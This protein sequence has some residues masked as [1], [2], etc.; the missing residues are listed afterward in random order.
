MQISL[1]Q[2]PF[3]WNLKTVT[4]FYREMASL[5]LDTIYIGNTVCSKRETTISTKQWL[6]IAEK[7]QATDKKVIFSTLGLI[8]TTAELSQ[9]TN[10]CADTPFLI[11][12]NDIGT[13][14][15]LNHHNKEFACGPGINIYNHNTAKI[16]QDK[17]MVRWTPPIE[18]SIN[19]IAEIKSASENLNA[20][21]DLYAFG[22]L[23]L[24]ISARCYSARV[25]E[26]DKE[27][28][29]N[30]CTKKPYG[31]MVDTTDGRDFLRINGTQ[32]MS[33]AIHNSLNA[34]KLAESTGIDSLRISPA[35][36]DIKQVIEQTHK[37]LKGEMPAVEI[38][39]DPRERFCQGFAFDGAGIE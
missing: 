7:L 25:E 17:G 10:I 22:Y 4:E 6:Q 35:N 8:E 37:M 18:I 39:L 38:D 20:T 34:W 14:N 33:G 21:I 9:L 11:E 2:I 1:S 26:L 29:D 28:C 15:I 31:H 3:N 32:T 16:L 23:P 12:A 27:H 19:A 5:P 24:A 36:A 30:I 13:V